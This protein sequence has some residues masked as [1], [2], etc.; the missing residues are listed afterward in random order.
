MILSFR[1]NK[2]ISDASARIND[3]DVIMRKLL[4]GPHYGSYPVVSQ[5]LGSFVQIT[6]RQRSLM[7]EP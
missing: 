3:Q 1:V 2:L 4:V 7:I 6:Y 5:C